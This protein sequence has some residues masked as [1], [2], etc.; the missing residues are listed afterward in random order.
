MPVRVR[1]L[2]RTATC[3]ALLAT[4]V[5]WTGV[6]AATGTG[7]VILTPDTVGLTFNGETVAADGTVTD[8]WTNAAGW[9]FDY[10][11]EPGG[12]FQE[13]MT[14]DSTGATTLDLAASSPQATITNH[15]CVKAIK[16]TGHKMTACDL[17]TALYSAPSNH[18][19]ADDMTSQAHASSGLRYNAI[20]MSYNWSANQI[21]T[22]DPLGDVGS[23][24]TQITL[25]A[26]WYG[27]TFSANEVTCQGTLHPWGQSGSKGGAIWRSNLPNPTST[28]GIE[29]ILKTSCPATTN[30]ASVLHLHSI[31]T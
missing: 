27:I 7:S 18:V 30:P 6:A 17:R 25:G 23:H 29:E 15:W 21:I 5:A 10:I 3:A 13:S 8:V 2:V 9:E 14:T 26:T 4:L 20:Y 28:I 22:M 24:C 11:G 31:W 12:T 19:I 1:R 16:G